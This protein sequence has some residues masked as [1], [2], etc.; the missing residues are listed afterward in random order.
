[1]SLQRV[2]Q[3]FAEMRLDK[4]TYIDAMYDIHSILFDYADF[5]Q[6]TNISKVEIKDSKVVMTFRDSGIQ[7]ICTRSDK[8]LAPFDTLNFGAY[9]TEELFMQLQLIEPGFKVF[10]I[11]GNYGW[12][13][14]HVAKHFPDAVIYSF[15]PIPST[16]QH[17]NENIELN[18]IS[19]I[20]TFNF[21]LSDQK[22]NF[23]FY[24][25]PALSVNASLTNVSGNA[26]IEEITCEV[27][28]LDDFCNTKKVEIDFIKCD[29]EGAELLALK[30]GLDSI[31]KHR[32]IIF[33][34][35]LRKWTAKFNYHPNDIIRLL[36][37]LN[38][39]CFTLQEKKLQP[40]ESVDEHTTNTNYFFLHEEKHA[41]K[42][43]KF[44]L[45][46]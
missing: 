37:D 10:D 36:V 2:K 23:K 40:F 22:G 29:V 20:Q 3:Q 31:K 16:Y 13:A 41:Q 28:T 42:I 12:Y 18:K 9:E 21:G 24:F 35:M 38:Y 30:G 4:W 14:L 19:N 5:I 7:F 1:M 25:D 11:G 44:L 46:D 43:E 17:L 27:R 33:A 15:E 32:P 45:H 26:N 34:E 39:K 8:R 6:A